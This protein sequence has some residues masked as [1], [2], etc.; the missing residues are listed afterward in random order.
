MAKINFN[1]RV[2]VQFAVSELRMQR[3]SWANTIREG[4]QAGMAGAKEI[5]Y[6]L[7][8]VSSVIILAIE[9][10]AAG[11]G[12][13][14]MALHMTLK[15]LQNLV[16]SKEFKAFVEMT[17]LGMTRVVSKRDRQT[18]RK[19]FDYLEVLTD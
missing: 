1:D 2:D 11:N 16:N 6:E 14:K 8:E 15:K 4:W 3:G 10:R 5:L 13:D 17:D 7:Y 12:R 9:N 19:M 18:I